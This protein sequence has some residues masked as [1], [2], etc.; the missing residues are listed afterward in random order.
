[1]KD[2]CCLYGFLLE[3]FIWSRLVVCLHIVLVNI[4]SRFWCYGVVVFDFEPPWV[5]GIVFAWSWAPACFGFCTVGYGGY[6]A[7]IALGL[8]SITWLCIFTSIIQFFG[9]TTRVIPMHVLGVITG[10]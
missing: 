5:T 2:L 7:K 4:P 8:V 1:M 3:G 9:K 6:Y 10:Q